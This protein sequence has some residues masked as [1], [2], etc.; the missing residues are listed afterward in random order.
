MIA[1]PVALRTAVD[2]ACAARRPRDAAAIAAAIAQAAG[3][4]ATD[5]RLRALAASTQLA[6]AM[7]DT[8]V[9]QVQRMLRADDLLALAAS[10]PPRDGDV[11]PGLVGHV[12][13]SNVPALALPAIAHALLVGA[14]VVLK[15]GRADQLSAPLFCEALAAVEPSLAATIVPT[16]WPG[17]A[18]E[19]E[20][21]AFGNANVLV[22]TG[23]DAT[24][25]ALTDRFGATL[26]A[27]GDRS[28]VVVIASVPHGADRDALAAAIAYDTALYDQRG[29]LS[30]HT[31]FVAGADAASLAH[32][33]D[34]LLQQMNM[35]AG[36]LPAGP[37]DP[38]ARAVVRRACDDAE[39]AAGATV[40]RSP[41]GIVV[42]DSRR[43]LLA[44][45]GGRTL[46]LH[47]LRRLGDLPSLLPAGR[48]ESVGAAGDVTA[49][50][51]ALRDLGVSRVCRP[52]TMQTPPIHWPRGQRAPLSALRNVAPRASM[53]V[54]LP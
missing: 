41:G 40:R 53:L 19:W 26:R 20:A 22:G 34:L 24:I 17:G 2:A 3:I 11:A 25:G 31:V 47:S 42:I 5:P 52:G 28:S 44:P 30:P 6:P 50:L 54:E 1:T 32:F 21:A 27:H 46:R 38:A 12:L 23:G 29:C 37:S 35:I 10:D 39:W 4:W 18:P 49:I 45:I 14:A 51:P 48:I 7:I 43:E 36:R 16:Y 33:A 8:V 15:S 13:A 9:A